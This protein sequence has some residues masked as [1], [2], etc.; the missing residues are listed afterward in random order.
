[1]ARLK[2]LFRQLIEQLPGANI[3]SSQQTEYYSATFAGVQTQIDIFLPGENAQERAA[4]FKDSLPH[5][6]FALSRTIV[7]D[8]LVSEITEHVAGCNLKIEALLLDD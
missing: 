1:M 5:A 6:E 8:I 4:D 2:P 7:A 3:I